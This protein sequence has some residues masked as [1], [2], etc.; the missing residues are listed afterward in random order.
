MAGSVGR[1]YRET[2]LRILGPDQEDLPPGEVGEIYLRSSTSGIY[3]YLG[4]ARRLRTTP[5]GFGT[6]GVWVVRAVRCEPAGATTQMSNQKSKNAQ[7]DVYAMRV[8]S[9]DHAG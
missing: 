2:E 5:D 6:A 1:G 9:G 4:D 7:S 8:P 3:E